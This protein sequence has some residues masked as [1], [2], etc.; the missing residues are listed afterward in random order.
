MSMMGITRKSFI[1]YN[2]FIVHLI[3]VTSD[4]LIHIY[5]IYCK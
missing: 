1:E 5:L 4:M 3:L 2:I